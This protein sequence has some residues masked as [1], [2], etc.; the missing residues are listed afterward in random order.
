VEDLDRARYI[1]LTTFRR[2]GSPVSCPVWITG[3]GGNYVFT[4]GD[5]AWKTRRL[6]RNASVQVQACDMR[7]RVK[8]GAAVY[9]GT[10]EVATSREAVAAAEQALSAKYGWQFKAT[11]VVDGVRARFGR[12][13]DQEVVA[14]RLSLSEN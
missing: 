2:D 3:A 14:I 11:K 6:L 12:G 8:P 4:T 5:T 7:G 10:G 13:A 9:T 1:S